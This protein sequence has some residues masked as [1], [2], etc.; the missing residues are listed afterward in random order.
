M[1]QRPLMQC[2]W[3]GC[4]K[5]THDRPARCEKHKPQAFGSVQKDRGSF[6]AR[7]Y[8]RA[9]AK[10]RAQ[11]LRE[12]P[13]CGMR[14]DG[15]RS[16]EHSMCTRAGRAVLATQVDHIRLVTGPD[17]AGFMDPNNWQS[18]CGSCHAAKSAREGNAAKHRAHEGREEGG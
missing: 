5:L 13:L 6:A 15:S 14:F 8:T 9:W 2:S 3:P 7:G 18:I 1:P 10:A 16:P 4:P 11:W 17:D 12:R